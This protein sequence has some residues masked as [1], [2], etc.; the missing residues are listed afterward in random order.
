MTFGADMGEKVREITEIGHSRR[1]DDASKQFLLTS[2][3]ILRRHDE[4]K[5]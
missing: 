4:M 1:T 2:Q 3:A 5:G